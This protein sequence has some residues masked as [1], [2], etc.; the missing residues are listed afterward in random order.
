MIMN[1]TPL[2]VE[3]LSKNNV[4]LAVISGEKI[5]FHRKP[6]ASFSVECGKSGEFLQD[7][8]LLAV[9]T[10]FTAFRG[11]LTKKERPVHGF[12][13]LTSCMSQTSY[14]TAPFVTYFNDTSC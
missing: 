6:P 11:V 7:L 10:F 3:V 5:F 14:S 12:E 13:P 1:L 2:R 9:K 8:R 4:R